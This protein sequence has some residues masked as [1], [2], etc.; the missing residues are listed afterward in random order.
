MADRIARDDDVLL[1]LLLL[2]RIVDILWWRDGLGTEVRGGSPLGINYSHQ[3]LLDA[4]ITM[5]AT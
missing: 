3:K 2:L 5:L 1:L 4:I